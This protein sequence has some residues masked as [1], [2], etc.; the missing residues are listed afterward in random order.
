MKSRA[1]KIGALARS[2]LFLAV[3]SLILWGARQ[4][5]QPATPAPL[6]PLREARYPG[7]AHVLYTRPRPTINGLPPVATPAPAAVDPTPVHTEALTQTGAAEYHAQGYT[8][9]GVAVAVMD[10]DFQGWPEAVRREELP[11]G[12]LTRRFTNGAQFAVLSPGTTGHGVACAEIVYDLAPDATLYLIQVDDLRR[13][14]AP[15]LDY[16]QAEGVRV[17]SISLSALGATP[18]DTALN[19]RLE[20]ARRAG[21]LL[22]VSAGNYA[23]QHYAGPFTDLDSDGWHEFG[24]GHAALGLPV[25]AEQETRFYLHWDDLAAHYVLHLFDEAGAEVARSAS[26]ASPAELAFTPPISARYSFRIRQE[27]GP[28]AHLTLFVSGGRYPLESHQVAAGSL[29]YP[30]D[31]PAVL[32]VGAARASQGT[33]AEY[34]SRGPTADGRIKPDL[35]GYAHVTVSTPEYALEKFSGTSA[36][37]PHV[38]GLAALLLSRDTALDPAGL[39]AELARF[40]IDQGAPGK[41]NL[42]GWG[43]AQLPPLDVQARLLA[44]SAEA[45]PARVQVAVLRSDGTP[46]RGLR[47]EAFTAT[48]GGRP[49]RVLTARDFGA[50]YT[51]DVRPPALDAQADLALTVLDITL[52][53]P[54]A[55]PPRREAG[56]APALDVNTARAS[57]QVGEPLLLL[58]SLTG[59]AP[60][61]DARVTV[62]I[63]GPAGEDTLLLHDDGQHGDGVA[64]DGVYG[65]TYTRARRVGR[66]EF[67]VAASGAGFAVTQ[68]FSREIGPSL[69]DSDGDGMPDNWEV[70][71]GLNPT[72]HDAYRDPDNDGLSNL[73]EYR[74]GSDPHD[75]DTDGDGLNDR[76]E[77]AGYYVTNPTNRDTDLGGVDDATELINGTNPL[78]GADDYRDRRALYLPTT[79]RDHAPL[80]QTIRQITRDGD[81]LW[82]ATQ[83]GAVYWRLTDGAYRKYTPEDGLADHQVYASA[84][85]AAGRVWFATDRGVSRW[86]GAVWTTYTTADGLT[87]QRTRA[88]YHDAAGRVWV[89]TVQGLSVYDG[90]RWTTYTTADGL[91]HHDI[92]ALAGDTAGRVWVGTRGGLARWDGAAW[93]ILP[94]PHAW[95]NALAVDAAGDLWIGTWGGGVSRWDGAAWGTFGVAEGLPDRYIYALS[96]EAGQVWA[97]TDRALYAFDGARWTR[98]ALNTGEIAHVPVGAIYTARVDRRGRVLVGAQPTVE[99]PV[100]IAL[101]LNAERYRWFGQYPVNA[102]WTTYALAAPSQEAQPLVHT[103]AVDA[104][105]RLWVGTGHGVTRF[106]GARFSDADWTPHTL[107]GALAQNTVRAIY[108]TAA[109][110]LWVGTSG[111]G[112]FRL[113]GDAAATPPYPQAWPNYRLGAGPAGAGPVS[114]YIDAIAQD[115]AGR[116]WFGSGDGIG[117]VSVFDGATWAAFTPREGLADHYVRAIAQDAAGRLWFGTRAGVSVFDGSAWMTLTSRDGLAGDAVQSLARDAAGRMWVGTDQGLSVFDGAEWTTHLPGVDI[118][119]LACAADGGLWVGSSAGAAY[120][121]GAGWRTYTPAEGLAGAEVTAIACAEGAVWFATSGGVSR[122]APGE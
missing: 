88:L 25:K 34:S 5:G 67:H 63:T 24:A 66:Y 20:E 49:A 45:A 52:T 62:H 103:L 108:P 91:P 8:G 80:P 73:D 1:L 68:T 105:G 13:D 64:G 92:R 50:H 89:G 94:T 111:A 115:A 106:S 59:E 11:A 61:P 33:L 100:T 79:L 119:A 120:F 9:A 2:L 110:D 85:D 36:A 54:G 40:A 114:N 27:A 38:A 60:V 98:Y 17:V 116:L 22:V 55:I 121:D 70:A 28:P 37:A 75:W 35:T 57:Y 90:Q 15:A 113:P 56:S 29:A 46:L 7:D 47:P 104:A 4:H 65:G 19:A 93:R 77:V 69:S 58:A 51:L 18:D 109:G 14:L 74:Y 96:V 122:F 118:R 53:A 48:V 44:V 112:V 16:L 82:L 72:I 31:S 76:E 102:Q 12:V 84:P 117:G 43:L 101:L 83:S 21:M 99:L 23:R 81:A 32:A 97:R 10:T 41:D 87:H 6:L 42:W 107:T 30:A 26:A 95:I 78:D 3:T 71:Y 39:E 86:D